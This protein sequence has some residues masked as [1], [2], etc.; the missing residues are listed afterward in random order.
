MFI[1]FSLV[2]FCFLAL[3]DLVMKL[4]KLQDKTI[5]LQFFACIVNL[6]SWVTVPAI[7]LLVWMSGS[8]CWS[9][10]RWWR[11]VPQ[12][13]S[14]QKR[15]HFWK[16]KSGHVFLRRVTWWKHADPQHRQTLSVTVQHM[17]SD[18]GKNLHPLD[19]NPP[20]PQFH[21]VA[22]CGS[23]LRLLFPA[24]PTHATG[25]VCTQM[26]HKL[27]RAMRPLSAFNFPH[28]NCQIKE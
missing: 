8:G 3:L 9:S 13:S 6:F 11:A 18:Y 10:L 12:A 16:V 27:V 28:I 21:S 4:L 1:T 14:S 5:C 7:T 2:Y 23:R 25:G 17:S 26:E 15:K 20:P 24:D 22:L 19:L